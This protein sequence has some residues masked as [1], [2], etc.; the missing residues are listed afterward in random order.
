MSGGAVGT[1][2]T[3]HG[4]C[5]SPSNSQMRANVL[6]HFAYYGGRLK[7][8]LFV[9]CGCGCTCTLQSQ[10]CCCSKR[11][12]MRFTKC[13]IW[14]L[15]DQ[16]S[17][18]IRFDV[19][20]RAQNIKEWPL[21]GCVPL[22]HKTSTIRSEVRSFHCH[23]QTFHCL[24]GYVEVSLDIGK[25]HSCHATLLSFPA[26]SHGTYFYLSSSSFLSLR[27]LRRFSEAFR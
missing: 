22:E 10:G 21:A 2:T 6:S 8:S 4:G 1:I 18:D 15:L 5:H 17:Y 25:S 19:T 26:A 24:L 27:S 20:S 7:F 14:L 13:R 11:R 23:G 9:A 16:T 3:W 12:G